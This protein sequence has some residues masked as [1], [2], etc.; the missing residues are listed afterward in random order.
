MK[1][2]GAG[3]DSRLRSPSFLGHRSALQPSELPNRRYNHRS[4]TAFH[5]RFCVEDGALAGTSMTVKRRKAGEGAGLHN[6]PASST[7]SPR[8]CV[9]VHTDVDRLL[10][11]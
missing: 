11:T 8:S 5:V 6:E 2:E 10:P 1:G 3:P 9:S 7:P 4:Q